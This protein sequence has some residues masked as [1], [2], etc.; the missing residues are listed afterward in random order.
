MAQ[1]PFDDLDADVIL[2]TADNVDFYA[3]RNENTATKRISDDYVITELL[4]GVVDNS[5]L[6]FKKEGDVIYAEGEIAQP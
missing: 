3:Y 6:T 2:R 1:F 5:V 4:L